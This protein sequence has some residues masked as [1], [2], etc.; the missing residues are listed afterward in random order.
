MTVAISQVIIVFFTFYL[1]VLGVTFLQLSL[2]CYMYTINTF[3]R[4]M[5]RKT[6]RQM[7]RQRGTG[8]H[9]ADNDDA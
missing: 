4:L 9:N 1:T 7:K 2:V 3:T 6:D 5:D 8:V